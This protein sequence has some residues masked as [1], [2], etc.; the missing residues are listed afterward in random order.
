MY[1]IQLGLDNTLYTHVPRMR[2]VWSSN[3]GPAKSYSAL[4]TVRHRFNIYRHTFI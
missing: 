4:Q 3:L 2:E 1:E